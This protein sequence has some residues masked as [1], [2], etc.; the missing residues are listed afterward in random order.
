MDLEKIKLELETTL[1][2][3]EARVQGID[4]K[5]S[6]T[7]DPDWEENAKESEDDEVLN[8][9]GDLTSDEIHHIRLALKRIESGEYGICTACQSKIGAERLEALPFATECIRCA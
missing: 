1:R 7:P 6:A 5:L 4:A 8:K 9:L 3:L 2:E